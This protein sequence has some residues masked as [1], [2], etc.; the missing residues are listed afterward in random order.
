MSEQFLLEWCTQHLQDVHRIE[1]RLSQIWLQI[2]QITHSVSEREGEVG[3]DE[4]HEK[5]N[6]EM[7]LGHGS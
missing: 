7:E 4:K 6:S 3:G 1:F 2:G 5:E